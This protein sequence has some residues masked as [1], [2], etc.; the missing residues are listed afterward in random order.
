LRAESGQWEAV[1]PSVLPEAVRAFLELRVQEEEQQ[2][3]QQLQEGY[4]F[5]GMKRAVYVVEEVRAAS[6]AVGR[7]YVCVGGR[8]DRCE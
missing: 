5:E 2:Q 1:T 7:V 4:Y 3:Q 8:S 6:A